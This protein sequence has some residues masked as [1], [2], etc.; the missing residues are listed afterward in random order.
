MFLQVA[1]VLEANNTLMGFV[2]RHGKKGSRAGYVERGIVNSHEYG[3]EVVLHEDLAVDNAHFT[4][5]APPPLDQTVGL[6]LQLNDRAIRGGTSYP[7]SRQG[8][9]RQSIASAAFV[10]STQGERSSLMRY[11]QEHHLAK[12]RREQTEIDFSVD[13]EYLD[14]DKPIP[15]R[16][17]PKKAYRPSKVLKKEYRPYV[18]Y[19]GA[20]LDR[21]NQ[22]VMWE[23]LVGTGLADPE[24]AISMHPDMKNAHE[25]LRRVSL[26][27]GKDIFEQKL[28][29]QASLGAS[30]RYVELLA[31]GKEW[32]EAAKIL[33]QEGLL[34]IEL[35]QQGTPGPAPAPQTPEEAMLAAQKGAVP[36]QGG[37]PFEALL[38]RGPLPPLNQVVQ[39]IRPTG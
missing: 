18:T 23:Q 16:G 22:T 2:I 34:Q 32:V 30:A 33:N 37:L 28:Q 9:V 25:I 5:V 39:N 10:A 19:G 3:E 29:A 27:R 26:F 21:L 14:F 11:I 12:L 35:P 20:G 17:G 24:T 15:S 1:N 36:E 31:D 4:P 8:D 38:G 6:A 7:A 13:R